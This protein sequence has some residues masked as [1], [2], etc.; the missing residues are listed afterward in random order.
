MRKRKEREPSSSTQPGH[1][2]HLV[3]GPQRRP[4]T[5]RWRGPRRRRRGNP[6]DRQRLGLSS[7]IPCAQA[8]AHTPEA[9]RPYMQPRQARNSTLA[10]GHGGRWRNS[11]IGTRTRWNSRGR[12]RQGTV[13]LPRGSLGAWRRR[14]RNDEDELEE[15]A[16]TADYKQGHAVT[17]PSSF[18]GFQGTTRQELE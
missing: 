16:P 13:G 5:R 12:R 17:A 6:Q 7:R 8:S 9:F 3:P 11:T 15:E 4:E 2:N 1:A 18:T 14:E 10:G